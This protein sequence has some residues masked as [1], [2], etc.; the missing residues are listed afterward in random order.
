MYLR[1]ISDV[2][3]FQVSPEVLVSIAS[4]KVF[5]TT[6]FYFCCFSEV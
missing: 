3:L 2:N 6:T 1:E 4:K 5:I